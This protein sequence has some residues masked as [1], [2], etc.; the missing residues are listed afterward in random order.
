MH[1]LDGTAAAE[2]LRH[3]ASGAA[4][5]VA[6]LEDDAAVHAAAP[7]PV[8]ALVLLVFGCVPRLRSIA[9]P[10]DTWH[11]RRHLDLR[12][13]PL[14]PLIVFLCKLY[15]L[16]QVLLSQPAGTVCILGMFPGKLFHLHQTYAGDAT[17]TEHTAGARRRGRRQCFSAARTRGAHARGATGPSATPLCSGAPLNSRCICYMCHYLV[18]AADVLTASVRCGRGS[19]HLRSG[20]PTCSASLQWCV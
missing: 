1:D 8:R 5:V 13:L 10:E 17:A 19:T 12:V 7:A 2:A 6:M 16:R 9:S 11:D 18:N 15:V 4:A 20:K 3:A 14:A